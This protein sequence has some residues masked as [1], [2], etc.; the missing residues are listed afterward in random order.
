LSDP[1][2]NPGVR[3][4]KPVHEAAYDLSAAIARAV[5]AVIPPGF[6]ARIEIS[7]DSGKVLPENVGVSF[8]PVQPKAGQRSQP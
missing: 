7:V 3:F 4:A 1:V 2:V 6:R 5:Q 8:R